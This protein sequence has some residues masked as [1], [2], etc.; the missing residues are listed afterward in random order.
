[1]KAQERMRIAGELHDGVMQQIT[2]LSLVLGTAKRKIASDTE[3]KGMVADVQR[4]LIDAGTEERDLSHDLNPPLLKRAGLPEA[5]RGYC[6]SF[7]HAHGFAVS[8]DIDDSVADLSPGTALALH[9]I[10]QR[11]PGTR[12]STRR[13]PASTCGRRAPAATSS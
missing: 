8:C 4:R 11:R 10:A 13:R 12:R 2:A 6:D 3:A 7:G 9:R 1:M 5:L